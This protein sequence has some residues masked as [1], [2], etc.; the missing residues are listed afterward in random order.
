MA[1]L[2]HHGDSMWLKLVLG[3]WVTTNQLLQQSNKDSR[4][5]VWLHPLYSEFWIFAVYRYQSQPVRSAQTYNTHR[6]AVYRGCEIITKIKISVVTR[7]YLVKSGQ[8]RE[9]GQDKN[10]ISWNRVKTKTKSHEIGS[11]QKQNLMKSSQHKNEIPWNRV[12]T[13]TRSREI[14]STQNEISGNR[15]IT[16]F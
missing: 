6:L 4:V 12:I 2:H 11:M 16:G 15:V 1:C 13:K 10:E 14:W 5:P 3:C 7:V 8:H 9:I